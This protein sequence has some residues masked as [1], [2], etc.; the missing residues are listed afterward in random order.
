MPVGKRVLITGGEGFVGRRLAGFASDA[1]FQVSAPGR[2]A[3]NLLDP[4]QVR[5]AIDRTQP[6][7]VV[8]LASCG[9]SAAELRDWR[10]I[11]EDLEMTA[12]LF[13]ALPGG[14]RVIVAGS[15]SEYGRAGRMRE[16][17][18]CTPHTDYGLAKLTCS[19]YAL[20]HGRRLGLDV[21]VARLFGVYGPGEGPHRLIP[22]LMD[23]LPKEQVVLLSDGTQRRDFVHVDDVCAVLIDI[24]QL[25]DFRFRI[26]NVG[27][28]VA[29][30]LRDVCL[31]IAA[32]MNADEALLHFGARPRNSTDEDVI[33]A[34][35]SRLQSLIGWAPPQRLQ[36][37]ALPVL[38]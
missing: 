36:S 35:T 28:G 5:D 14:V 23:R 2:T 29:L 18:V 12:N 3:L 16:N 27:T 4:A 30:P 7:I 22:T 17:D 15:M 19:L 11:S 9:V 8:H 24:A 26:V 10:C 37:A 20:L 6:E 33:E 25:P 1:G 38:S 13:A 34:D 32:S 31:R 21:A